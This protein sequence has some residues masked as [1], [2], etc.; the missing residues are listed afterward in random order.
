MCRL[1]TRGGEALRADRYD[2]SMPGAGRIQQAVLTVTSHSWESLEL[3]ATDPQPGHNIWHTS[4][5]PSLQ[6]GPK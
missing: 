6:V 5:S 3:S 2:S 1:L 4:P